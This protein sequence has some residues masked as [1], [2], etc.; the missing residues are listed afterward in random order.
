[1]GLP[2]AFN[3]VPLIKKST[4]VSQTKR[5]C[6]AFVLN[7]TLYKAMEGPGLTINFL[8]KLIFGL[9]VLICAWVGSMKILLR[10]KSREASPAKTRNETIII[11]I[12][13]AFICSSCYLTR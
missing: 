10:L 8:L 12:E 3:N 1:M 7:A 9:L 2:L 11:K 6:D 4:F 5:N 13:S